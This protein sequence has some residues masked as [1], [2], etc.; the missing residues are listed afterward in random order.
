MRVYKLGPSTQLQITINCTHSTTH[1]KIYSNHQTR[2][3]LLYFSSPPDYNDQH[4]PHALPNMGYT[5]CKYDVTNG[6][7]A[8][9]GTPTGVT[10]TAGG[11]PV[12]SSIGNAKEV[13]ADEANKLARAWGNN[14]YYG[15][16]DASS[17]TKFWVKRY[18]DNVGVACFMCHGLDP[19]SGWTYFGF[20]RP[21]SHTP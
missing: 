18:S 17:A 13:A 6:V 8:A 15:Q 10:H 19:G 21:L 3:K 4:Y 2:I 14:Q 12:A 11:Q 9:T 7:A 16:Q 5:V 20:G 1:S